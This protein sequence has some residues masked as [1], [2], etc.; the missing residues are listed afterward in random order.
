MSDEEF[1]ALKEEIRQE[2]LEEFKNK[3]KM[4]LW[5]KLKKQYEE[6]FKMFNY[7]KDNKVTGKDFNEYI[8][9]DEVHL[10]DEVQLVIATTLKLI[11][12]E[13]YV[14]RISADYEEVKLIVENIL[15]ILKENRK[16][17][18]QIQ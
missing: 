4:T 15:K 7:T 13:R 14:D 5:K 6:D 17:A 10:E 9:K 11:Y 18:S 1:N 16:E 12:K 8:R 2:L 3:K